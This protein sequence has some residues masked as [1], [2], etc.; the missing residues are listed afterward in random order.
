MGK[1]RNFLNVLI[2]PEILSI[3]RQSKKLKTAEEMWSGDY[4]SW[5]EAQNMCTGYDSEEILEKCKTALLKVKNGKAVYERDSVLFDKIE[6]SY[7]LLSGLMWIAALNEG[8]LN[9]ID[10]GGSLGS[11]Y[12][13]NRVFINSLKQVRWSIIEQKKF[14]LKGKELFE[15]NNLKFYY[16]IEECLSENKPNVII[17]SGVLQYLENPFEF[18]RN[19]IKLKINFIIIDLTGFINEPNDRITVQK[20]DPVIYNASYPCWFFNSENFIDHFEKDYYMVID[21]E[22]YVGKH[23]LIDSNINVGYRGFIFKLK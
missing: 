12:F 5:A 21:F 16:T 15:D 20:V 9:V 10:F 17:L 18:I 23:L 4:S 2:P 19:I 3:H 11:T 6:Y 1:F 7:P 13:Q 22:G 8:K 14:V